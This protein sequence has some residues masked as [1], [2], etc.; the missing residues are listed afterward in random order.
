[1]FHSIST[2]LLL[3]I[4]FNAGALSVTNRQPATSGFTR[5]QTPP[6]AVITLE[7]T[8]C[9]G[10]CP[11]Y[12]LAIYSDGRV[13][14]EGIQHVKKL[15]RAKGRISRARLEELVMEFTNIYYFNLPQSFT[16][17]SKQCPQYITDM[18]SAITSLTWRERSKTIEHYHGCRGSRTLENLT[19][20]EH[21][22]DRAVNITRWTK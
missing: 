16:P 1:M 19:E 15:G 5:F 14:Y 2:M 18:P 21:K 12:K 4:L 11:I 6:T 8:A 17:G 13:G 22:I 3:L 9:Y 7:R 20:L 10:T